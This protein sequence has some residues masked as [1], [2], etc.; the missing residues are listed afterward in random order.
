M[1]PHL[2]TA[3]TGPLLSLE[4]HL[5]HEMA[6]IEHWFRTQWLEH[7][8]NQRM[9]KKELNAPTIVSETNAQYWPFHE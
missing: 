9:R 6:K 4:K 7:S 2:K 3:L 8:L 1:V 5:I